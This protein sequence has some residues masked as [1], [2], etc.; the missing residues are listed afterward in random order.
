MDIRELHMQNNAYRDLIED[1]KRSIA[2]LDRKIQANEIE[3]GKELQT[4]AEGYATEIVPGCV[5]C[6]GEC[7]N[8]VNL[9]DNHNG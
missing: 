6:M 1:L 4:M 7:A 8:D 5:M 2:N 3:I 9:G